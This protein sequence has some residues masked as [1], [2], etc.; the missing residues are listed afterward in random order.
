MGSPSGD[1]YNAEED[2]RYRGRRLTRMVT[3][4]GA[5]TFTLTVGRSARNYDLRYPSQRCGVTLRFNYSV[6]DGDVDADGVS[7]GSDALRG[8]RIESGRSSRR[9]GPDRHGN[10]PGPRPPRRCEVSRVLSNVRLTSNPGPDRVYGIG[11]VVEVSVTFD[12]SVTT[13]AA[14]HWR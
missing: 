14:R 11:D 12:E 9:S 2:D 1:Y 10:R 5:P 7:Y 3:V 8:G 6:V 13:L 4:T